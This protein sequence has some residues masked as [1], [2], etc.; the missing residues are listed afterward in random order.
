VQFCAN[1]PVI[2]IA[3]A[4]QDNQALGD[5]Y[6][7][8]DVDVNDDAVLEPQHVQVCAGCNAVADA[9]TNNSDCSCF[10]ILLQYK[11]G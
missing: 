8:L 2:R 3:G 10:G 11:Q 4:V 9:A 6:H 5:V 7:R 1:T